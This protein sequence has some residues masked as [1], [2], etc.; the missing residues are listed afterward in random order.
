MVCFGSLLDFW[1]C[2]AKAGL[3]G[4]L[5]FADQDEEEKEESSG[6]ATST[7]GG[8]VCLYHPVLFFSCPVTVMFSTQ[9]LGHFGDTLWSRSMPRSRKEKV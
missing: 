6:S 5:S 3:M 2:N 1:L 8:K 4:L 9:C 7:A